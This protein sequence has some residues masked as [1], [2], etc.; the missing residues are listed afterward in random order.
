MGIVGLIFGMIGGVIG[1]LFI[2]LGNIF[3]ST[4]VVPVFIAP[5]FDPFAGVL[6]VTLSVPSY[7]VIWLG[8]MVLTVTFILLGSSSIAVRETT[9]SSSAALAAGILSIIGACF[10]AFYIFVQ[11]YVP[12]LAIIGGIFALTG[13]TLIFVAFILW[14]VV[15]FSSRDI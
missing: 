6:L 13:F 9:N 15:F 2:L 1:P 4:M 12:I 14:T 8:M 7:I 5:L 10:L 11:G 3:T